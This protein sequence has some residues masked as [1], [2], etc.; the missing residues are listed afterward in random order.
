MIVCSCRGL[1]EDCPR[2]RGMGAYPDP[3]AL[4]APGTDGDDRYSVRPIRTRGLAWED[5]HVPAVAL[6]AIA[7]VIVALAVVLLAQAAT[8]PPP[9]RPGASASSAPNA[10]PTVASGLPYALAPGAPEAEPA[11]SSYPPALSPVATGSA[12]TAP[13]APPSVRGYATVDPGQGQGHAAAGPALRR[14]LGG[15][16]AFRGKLVTVVK[17]DRSIR[18]R[19]SDWCACG[20]RHGTDTVIDL[21]ETDFRTLT[22]RGP[23]IAIVRVIL[24]GRAI[25]LPPTDKDP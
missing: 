17:G 20:D 7:L 6:L 19:L 22:G 24:D 25:A 23:G 18:V 8:A 13:G 3:D 14:A 15:D 9:I 1:D 4:R 10:S 21:D 12:M 11:P 16:P 2:C 5:R